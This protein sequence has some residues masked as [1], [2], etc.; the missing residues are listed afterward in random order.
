MN[1]SIDL[2]YGRNAVLEALESGKELDVVYLQKG[3]ALDFERMLKQKTS[4]QGLTVKKLPKEA[5]DRMVK[6]NHQG[7]IAEGLLV[8]Y[9]DFQKELERIVKDKKW[10]LLLLLDGITDVRNFGAIARSAEVLGVDLLVIP[11]RNSVRITADALKTSSG[12]L[13][14]IPVARVEALE[15]CIAALSEQGVVVFASDLSSGTAI[16]DC[17]FRQPSAIIIGSEGKGISKKVLIY[18]DEKFLIPEVG[19]I[20]SLNASVA[21]GIALYEVHRQRYL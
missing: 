4:S 1:D 14:R 6:G 20:N 17:D 12:A 13:A 19:K 15:D 11:S 5:L 18:A 9:A 21:T 7:V 3:V 2:I 10:P 16:T 8:Q